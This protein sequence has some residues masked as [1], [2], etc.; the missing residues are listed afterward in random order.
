MG[1]DGVTIEYIVVKEPNI[2]L[3]VKRVQVLILSGYIPQGGVTSKGTLS[4]GYMQA[5]IKKKQNI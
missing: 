5:M 1:K 4:G 2:K 3:L